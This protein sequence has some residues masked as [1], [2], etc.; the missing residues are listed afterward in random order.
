MILSISLSTLHYNSSSFH[1]Y[2]IAIPYI[3]DVKGE[4]LSLST[5]TEG[6]IVKVVVTINR[7]GNHRQGATK[8]IQF[9]LNEDLVKGR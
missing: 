6:K 5:C 4:V 9:E 7:D 8:I 2:M 1:V 3:L